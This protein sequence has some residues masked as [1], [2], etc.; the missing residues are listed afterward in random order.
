MKRMIIRE[1]KLV[2]FLEEKAKKV[3]FHPNITVIR[4]D[5]HTGKS[6]LIKSIYWTFGADPKDLHPKWKNANVISL[7]K[8]SLDGEIYSILRKERFF[9]VFDDEMNVIDTFKGITNGIGPFIAQLFNYK[10]VLNNKKGESLIPPPAYFLLPFYIDQDVSW[11]RNWESFDRLSQFSNWRN[12]V[13]NYHTGIR[14]NEYYEINATI[15]NYKKEISELEN[16]REISSNFISKISNQIKEEVVAIDTVQFKK[17]IDELLSLYDVLNKKGTVLKQKI[18]EL[19]NHKI[20]IEQQI[21]VVNSTI[22]ELKD[23]FEFAMDQTDSVECPT[24]GNI[25]ENSFAERF[26]IAKDEDTCKDLLFIL[27]SDLKKIIESIQSEYKIYD[28]NNNEQEKIKDILSKKQGAVKLKDIILNEGKREMNLLMKE[29]ISSLNNEIYNNEQQIEDLKEDLK[30]FEDKKRKKEIRTKYFNLMQSNLMK[31][32]VLT[33]SEKSY[34]SITSKIAETGSGKPRA[35][36]AYYFSI[37]EIMK[38]YSTSVFCPIVI[39]SPNQQDQEK[40]NLDKMLD[41]IIEKKPEG[42]QL[43]L[44]LVEMN[45]INLEGKTLILNEKYSLLGKSDYPTISVE[46]KDLLEKCE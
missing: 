36:L 44:G 15:R 10:L 37:L 46:I 28:K 45:E 39:D 31:L 33:M 35:L 27:N 5:N 29:E 17:E 41:F 25:Y 8:F 38:E 13:V 24:C 11:N 32:D 21:K 16:E 1:I 40:A 20:H 6:S 7:V 12:D 9:A 43:I 30:E 14:P 42:S 2:S 4:G 23:D 3:T 26:A 19:E 34:K 18:L 22:D